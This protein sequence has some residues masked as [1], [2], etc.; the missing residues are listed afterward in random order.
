MCGV[1]GVVP[2]QPQRDV[3]LDGGGEVAGTAVEVGPG[4]VLA[5][6][7]ADPAG[8]RLRSSS[9][10][11]DAEELAAAA[12]PRRPSSR[13]S[14]ARP[15][16][17]R[18]CVPEGPRQVLRRH[19]R[20]RLVAG[21]PVR[22]RWPRSPIGSVPTAVGRRFI[23]CPSAVRLCGVVG[24]PTSTSGPR[25]LS[26]SADR[27]ESDRRRRSSGFHRPATVWRCCLGPAVHSRPPAVRRR[28]RGRPRAARSL[29]LFA[30]AGRRS[31]PSRSD[32]RA[33]GVPARTRPAGTS[34]AAAGRSRSAC[35]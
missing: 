9:L 1:V 15:S 7:G 6:L 33:A 29:R 16:T 26:S 19:G 2:G 3:R 24:R 12:G 28:R 22:A 8:G 14:R 13:S 27:H 18:C 17:S 34:C 4:A 11:A 30:S 31:S 21:A 10:V 32:A 5:L 20:R 25:R 35:R 23:G